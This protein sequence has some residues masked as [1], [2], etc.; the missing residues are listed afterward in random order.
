MDAR[1]PNRSS[2]RDL[3]RAFGEV[4]LDGPERLVGEHVLH[5]WILIPE[6]AVARELE[7]D[8]FE[9]LVVQPTRERRGR[10]QVRAYASAG[11]ERVD[12]VCLALMHLR[13]RLGIARDIE[14]RDRFIDATPRAEGEDFDW[15]T[16]AVT[17]VIEGHLGLRVLREP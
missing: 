14:R 13:R 10:R 2:D 4:L 16:F 1:F 9:G 6:V 3:H 5:P 7:R 11:L 15:V 17:V 12:Q 8:G